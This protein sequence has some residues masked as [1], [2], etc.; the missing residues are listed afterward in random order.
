MVVTQIIQRRARSDGEDCK[1]TVVIVAS[2]VFGRA[3]AYILQ[4]VRDSAVPKTAATVFS[5]ALD[6]FGDK[7]PVT[8]HSFAKE[9]D[10]VFAIFRSRG[11]ALYTA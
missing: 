7:G 5:R 1:P 11:R 3:A 10:I 6:S 8:C 9:Y 2:I 4:T